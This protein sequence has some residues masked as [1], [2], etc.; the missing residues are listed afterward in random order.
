MAGK[1]HKICCTSLVASP[2]GSPAYRGRQGII[3]WEQEEKL[4][5][6]T[7]GCRGGAD[8]TLQTSVGLTGQ[9][10]KVPGKTLLG[11][12][13]TADDSKG[14]TLLSCY[15]MLEGNNSFHL[16]MS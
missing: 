9:K 3:G 7:N 14:L 4:N 10:A 6:Q 2:G 11:T 16:E 13:T 5:L 1:P 15:R 8:R 12:H